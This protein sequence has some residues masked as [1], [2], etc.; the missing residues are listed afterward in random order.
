MPQFM[1]GT[2]FLNNGEDK[3][4]YAARPGVPLGTRGVTEDGRAFRLASANAA[5]EAGRVV[6]ARA[7]V[8]DFDMDLSVENGASVGDF[9]VQVLLGATTLGEDEFAGGEMYINDGPGEGH[10]Y[11]I[12]SH[13]AAEVSTP[14]TITLAEPVRSTLMTT[15][16]LAGLIHNEYSSVVE[17]DADTA[18]TGIKGVTPVAVAAGR[19][20]WCQ[21][22][23]RASVLTSSATTLPVVGAVVIPQLT[24]STIA[25]AIEAMEQFA[26]ALPVQSSTF[27]SAGV[28]AGMGT[29]DLPILGVAELIQAVDT[30]YQIVFLTIKP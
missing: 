6:Q 3:V 1:Y 9:D 21:T 2:I 8:A 25:G 24:S 17:I 22:W 12:A 5:L 7:G 15:L 10:L 26:T 28:P 27:A 4:T 16:S 18:L 20:F 13:A 23:G 11:R 29:R 19:F 14:A 30:D